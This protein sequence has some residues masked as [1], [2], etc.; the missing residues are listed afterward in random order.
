MIR[1]LLLG[2]FCL[3]GRVWAE[4]N[5]SPGLSTAGSG[6][7]ASV[8]RLLVGLL[9]VIGL[10]VLLGWLARRMQLIPRQE[11]KAIRIV[12]TQPLGPRERLLLV[13]VGREQVLLGLCHGQL[14][15][16]HVLAE[17][18]DF[19][20]PSVDEVRPDFAQRLMELMSRTDKDKP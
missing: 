3:P 5:T 11:G 19:P 7:E 13:Q 9:L 17:P 8:S 2:A 10:I 18:V 4:A 16:L 1:A 6:L 12:A 20:E 14:T 15:P